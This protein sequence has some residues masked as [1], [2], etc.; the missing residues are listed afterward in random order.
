MRWLVITAA[1]L[2]TACASVP[3][4]PP[5]TVAVSCI[6]ANL[7]SK[8][9]VEAPQT[10][11]AIPDGASRYVRLAAAYIRLWARSLEVEP[12]IEACRNI[13]P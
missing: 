5:V 7:S 1:L 9:S 8:P 6:P 10:L 12:V 3:T 4:A 13:K 11:A 2:V